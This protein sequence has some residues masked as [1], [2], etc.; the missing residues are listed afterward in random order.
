MVAL[1]ARRAFEGR[2]GDDVEVEEGRGEE[3]EGGLVGGPGLVGAGREVDA[4]EEGNGHAVH[5]RVPAVWLRED[6]LEDDGGG[7]EVHVPVVC[8]GQGHVEDEELDDALEDAAA[9]LELV[10]GVAGHAVGAG[11][12]DA[13]HVGSELAEGE[14][15]LVAEAGDGLHAAGGVLDLGAVED[16]AEEVGGETEGGVVK[17]LVVVEDVEEPAAAAFEEGRLVEGE[18]EGED[19]VEV[20]HD[21]A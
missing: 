18:E 12:V 4:L 19:V 10:L 3:A 15:H 7:I 11:L 6:L 21:E 20:D 17:G 13:G 5:C 1:E 16:D 14:V 9:L 2:G 8:G